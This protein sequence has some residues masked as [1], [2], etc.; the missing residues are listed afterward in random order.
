MIKECPFRSGGKRLGTRFIKESAPLIK[1]TLLSGSPG[2][3]SQLKLQTHFIASTTDDER[4]VNAT[5]KRVVNDPLRTKKIA[6]P[7]TAQQLGNKISRKKKGRK[8][9]AEGEVELEETGHEND[10]RV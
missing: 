9:L 4:R 3:A 1:E 2:A 8:T 6:A 7:E 10:K 5:R